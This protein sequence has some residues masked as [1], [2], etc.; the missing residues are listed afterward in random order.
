MTRPN[1]AH[2]IIAAQEK[3]EVRK[4][5]AL[6]RALTEKGAEVSWS[7]DDI[8]FQPDGFEANCRKA[9]HFLL[10]IGFREFP[11]ERRMLSIASLSKIERMGMI[12]L[13]SCAALKRH[14]T[15]FQRGRVSLVVTRS[16]IENSKIAGVV[17]YHV[18]C[19]LV[20]EDIVYSA[21]EI[22]RTLL[23]GWQ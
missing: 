23:I 20:A 8:F 3:V 6:T 11:R 16:P 12:C 2:V 19:S 22:A 5:D 18:S 21:P 9:T 7:R 14:Q 4:M 10:M 15:L 13:G 17:G 1:K